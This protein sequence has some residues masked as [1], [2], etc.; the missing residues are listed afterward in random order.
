MQDKKSKQY[1][2]SGQ[3]LTVSIYFIQ[4]GKSFMN[5]NILKY[6]ETLSVFTKN[7][8]IACLCTVCITHDQLYKLKLALS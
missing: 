2:L 3:N 1:F 5:T 8:S 6:L 7:I 4:F